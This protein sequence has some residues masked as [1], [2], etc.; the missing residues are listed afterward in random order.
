MAYVLIALGV[1]VFAV[2]LLYH[3]C[4]VRQTMRAVRNMQRYARGE[5][6]VVYKTLPWWAFWRE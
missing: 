2:A 3:D 6:L 5:P 1:N 4:R